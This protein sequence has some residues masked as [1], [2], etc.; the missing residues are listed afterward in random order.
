MLDLASRKAARMSLK[1]PRM[2]LARPV[3]SMA[4]IAMCEDASVAFRWER[5][6]SPGAD[7]TLT[8]AAMASSSLGSGVDRS[9][10]M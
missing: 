8:P 5:P 6:G 4:S 1:T 7:M 2:G 3:P 9:R 10:Q